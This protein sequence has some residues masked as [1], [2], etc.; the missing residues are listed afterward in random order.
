MNKLTLSLVA[1]G[2][3]ASG[4]VL[5][6]DEHSVAESWT[7]SSLRH[8]IAERPE[9]DVA[10]GAELN[11]SLMCSSCHGKEGIAPTPRWP[12]VAGQLESYTYKMLLD[13]HSNARREDNRANVMTAIS[14]LL[15]KQ[16]MSDIA[17]YYAS[18]ESPVLE[19]KAAP[20]LVTEGDP[21]R[22]I[23]PCASCH[24]LT[25]QGG[26]KGTPAIAGQSIET[27]QRA[28]EYYQSG[29]RDSDLYSV[30][31]QAS[32]KLTAQEIESLS[33]YYGADE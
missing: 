32:S 13:Y 29:H 16:D 21:E 15:S 22:L 8:A 26:I 7:A 1:A 2:L 30:M 19:V 4:V 23:T 11:E 18:L 5:A 6:S 33:A 12:S 27:L 24:G 28:L 20:M 25:G 10:R 31:R 3:L 9:G 17:A 14:E